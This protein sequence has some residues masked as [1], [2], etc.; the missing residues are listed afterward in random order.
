MKILKGD[1]MKLSQKV[2]L[3]YKTEDG[4]EVYKDV[5]DNYIFDPGKVALPTQLITMAKEQEIILLPP[6]NGNRVYKIGRLSKIIL[7]AV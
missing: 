3:T 2:L 7:K 1:N 5:P 4:E 6:K